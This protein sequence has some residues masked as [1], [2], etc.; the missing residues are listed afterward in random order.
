[1]KTLIR[2]KSLFQ[3]KTIWLNLLAVLLPIAAEII[4]A[5]VG[6]SEVL[7]FDAKT[8]TYLLLGLAI[9]NI[10]LRRVTKQPVTLK[11]DEFVE[12]EAETKRV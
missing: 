6:V 11:G 9:L 12:V 8:V 5:V 1:M 3:S 4:E 7:E 2:S 10:L